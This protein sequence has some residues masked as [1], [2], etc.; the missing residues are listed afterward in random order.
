MHLAVGPGLPVLEEVHLEFEVRV[1]EGDAVEIAQPVMHAV[2]VGVLM[3]LH[4]AGVHPLGRL[5][6]LEQRLVVR[7]LTPEDEAHIERFQQLDVCAIH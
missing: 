6:P 7:R 1:V 2:R 3:A 4:R 5:H